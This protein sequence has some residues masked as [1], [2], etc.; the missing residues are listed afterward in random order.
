MAC[1]GLRD[2]GLDS[3]GPLPPNARVAG[4]ISN[5]VLLPKVSVVV[6]NGGFQ[7]VQAALR[8]G[9]TMVTGRESEDKPE[10]SA[11]LPLTGASIDLATAIPEP[12]A[13]L[14]AVRRVLEGQSLR[15]SA[16]ALAQEGAAAGGAHE[17]VDAIEV[18]YSTC[19]SS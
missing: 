6:T 13:I 17:A 1:T 11:R 16:A 12:S 2:R 3:L 10:V 8:H 5:G 19:Q 15:I 9:I 4:Y 18:V 14:S 7:G